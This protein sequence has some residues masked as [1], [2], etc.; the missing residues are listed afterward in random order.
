MG[1]S[2]GP[3]TDGGCICKDIVKG[4]VCMGNRGCAASEV[5]C[6]VVCRPDCA[7]ECSGIDSCVVMTECTETDGWV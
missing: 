7:C 3:C 5:E 2:D 4:D 1:F 6:T